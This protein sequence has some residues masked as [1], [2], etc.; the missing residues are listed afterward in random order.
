MTTA[1]SL[2]IAVLAGT[3]AYFGWAAREIA[4]GV[5]PLWFVAG[6]P[7][8]AIAIP[9]AFTVLWLT[10]SWVFRAER[11][12]EMRL[13]LAGLLRLYWR[14]TM[15]IAASIPRMILYRWLM[16]DP[17]PVRDAVDASTKLPVLL[18]HGVLCNAG[19]WYEMRRSLAARGIGP[20]YALSYGP[21]LASIDRFADQTA[22]KIDA[23]RAATGAAQVVIVGHS[24]GGLVARAYLARYGGAKVRRVITIGTPHQGSVMAYMFPGVSL[25]QLRPRNAWLDDLHATHSAAHPPIVSLW[26]WHDS[27]V[28]PQ[29]SSVLARAENIALMGIGHNALLG[30]PEVAARVAAEIERAAADEPPVSAP[31]RSATE[32]EGSIS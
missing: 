7:L 19:V 21:P 31:T 23:I 27:M 17:A 26:S 4:D 20:V 22:T 10:L 18:L 16:A 28:A 25:S 9:A 30:D 2:A 5:S 1:I 14:E 29:T 12:P 6:I 13:D 3:I 32:Q 15:A 8:A 24:M 11:P